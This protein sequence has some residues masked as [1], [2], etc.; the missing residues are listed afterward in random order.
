MLGIVL[1]L[2]LSIALTSV[3]GQ[4]QRQEVDNIEFFQIIEDAENQYGIDEIQIE[5]YNV[6]AIDRDGR[7]VYTTTIGRLTDEYVR[8]AC[9]EADIPTPVVLSSHAGSFTRYNIARFKP[10]DFVEHVDFDEM[11]MENVRV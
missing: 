2:V 5:L 10:S 11:T 8:L 9:H 6:S 4:G 1:I 3:L 7:K